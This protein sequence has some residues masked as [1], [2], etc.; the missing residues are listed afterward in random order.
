M[1]DGKDDRSVGGRIR[2]LRTPIGFVVWDPK[3]RRYRF[4]E[5][6]EAASKAAR[7]CWRSRYRYNVAYIYVQ[8]PLDV[9]NYW[10]GVND[11]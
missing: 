2:K 9:L 11:T 10:G 4:F 1:G 7:R 6:E 3:T 5:D 8:D